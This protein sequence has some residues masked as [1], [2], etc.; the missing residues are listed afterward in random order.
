MAQRALACGASYLLRVR[1]GGLEQHKDHVTVTAVQ[2]GPEDGEARMTFRAWSVVVATGIRYGLL[3][4]LELK[5]PSAFL[6]AAQAEASMEGVDRVEVYLGRDV[7]P[8]SFAWAIP[9]GP[10]ARVGVG[11]GAGGVEDLP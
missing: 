2:R 7:A 8:G 10:V 5:R 6:Q 4:G 3:R 11:H 1:C 9:A